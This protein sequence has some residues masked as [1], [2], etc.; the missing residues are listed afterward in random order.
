MELRQLEYFVMVSEEAN[1]T[2]AAQR[3]RVAQPAVS[4]QIQR[5]ERELGQPLLDRSQRVVRLTTAG[6]AALPHAKA[7][8]AAAL[9]VHRAVDETSQLVRGTIRMGTV[10]SHSMDIP[11]LVAQFHALHP[12]VEITLRTSDSDALIDALR[13]GQLDLAAVAVG[14]DDRPDGIAMVTVTDETIGAVVGQKHVL[15]SESSIA[16]HALRDVPLIAMSTG[17]EI[18]RQLELACRGAGFIPHIAFEVGNP[19]ELADFAALGLGVGIMR[20]SLSR[21]RHDLHE[22]SIRPALRARLAVAWRASGPV[23]AAAQVLIDMAQQL[24]ASTTRPRSTPP[25][26]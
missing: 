7:A 15:A 1:F 19:S 17:T 23:G 14:A 20:Q 8:L 26:R 3:L 12:A 13:T 18:R 6:E 22:L 9:D 5:L 21:A 10:M 2:R 16:L 24:A 4:T 25:L 11:A